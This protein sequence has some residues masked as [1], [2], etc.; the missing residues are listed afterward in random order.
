MDQPL[1]QFLKNKYCHNTIKLVRKLLSWSAKIEKLKCSAD[2]L[3]DCIANHVIPNYIGFRIK[4]T[5]LKTSR[6]IEKAF[7]S[8]D[9]NK[10]EM[11][12]NKVNLILDGLIESL[13]VIDKQ[14]LILIREK[15]DKITTKVRELKIKKYCQTLEHLKKK[16][17]GINRVNKINNIVN[18]SN[19]KLNNDE[20]SALHLGLKFCIPWKKIKLEEVCSEFEVLAGQLEHHKALNDL[21][22]KTLNAKLVSIALEYKDKNNIH[23]QNIYNEFS[24]IAKQLISNPT[25]FI[26]KPDKGNGVVLLDKDTYLDKMNDILSDKSKFLKLGPVATYD[27]TCKIESAIQRRL[28]SLKKNNKITDFDYDAIRPSGSYRPR[29]YGLPKVHKVNI[30]LRPILSMTKSPQHKLAKWCVQVLK[31]LELMYSNHCTKDSFSFVSEVSQLNIN[32]D[33]ISMCSF[34]IKS[35]FTSL[36]IKESIQI[37]VKELF[38]HGLAPIHLNS[39]VFEE[40]LTIACSGVE[41]SFNDVMFKQIDGISM[42]SPLGP[43]IANIFVGFHENRLIKDVSP[44]YYKRYMDD[45]FAIFKNNCQKDS[46]FEKLNDM[47]ANLKFTMENSVDNKLAFLD[48]LVHWKN[49]K[50]YTSIYRKTTFTGDY[51]PFNSYSPIKQKINLIS[52]LTY[53]A[54]KICSD[55][56]LETELENVKNIFKDLGYPLDIIKSTIAKT[57]EKFECSKFGPK[58]CPV[59]LKLPYCSNEVVQENLKKTVENCYRSVKLRIV[60]KSNKLFK[61]DNKDKLPIHSCSNVIYKYVCFCK[62]TYVG[63]TGNNLINRIN[64]HL[65]KNL[66]NKIKVSNNDRAVGREQVVI[67]SSSAIGQHLVNNPNCFQ[68]YNLDNFKVIS[69]GRNDFHL[70]TLEAIYILCLKPVLC[71]QKNFV[72]STILF[73]SLNLN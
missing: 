16:K 22:K 71:R 52:C 65:P 24:K 53:R 1:F 72:Y 10:S 42:G 33:N 63:R 11:Q 70:K 62:Q 2:F 12:I 41:F 48:V 35:L 29:L 68:N 17:F 39:K 67:Q 44:V 40:L 32:Q 21:S 57:K 56:Y 59:Y 25:L 38:N 28:L 64:Q 23:N 31:P 30:P 37:C 13:N 45:T 20:K 7:C 36:P 5:K 15:I 9:I 26:S 49:K 19:Y 58:K 34:D 43:I 6:T 27:N 14:D 54:I 50:I 8:D 3:K 69:K 46:F 66:L 4:K 51:I 47:H 61:I 18:L 73:S 60:F 55:G